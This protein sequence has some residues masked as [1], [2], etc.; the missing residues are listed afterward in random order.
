MRDSVE[1]DL[2]LGVALPEMAYQFTEYENE[3][4]PEASS[5]R[6]GGPPRKLTGIG[7][8]DPTTSP[9]YP[10]KQPPPL[11]AVPVSLWLRIFVLIVLAGFAAL[12]LLSVLEAVTSH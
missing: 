6:S 11:P 12:T 7:V 1:R 8:L 3:L 10:R 2:S 5:A 9:K 4:V